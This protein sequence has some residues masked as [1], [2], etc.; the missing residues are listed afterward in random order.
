MDTV[1]AGIC[2][3]QELYFHTGTADSRGYAEGGESTAR[4]GV[5][6]REEAA[7]RCEVSF[8]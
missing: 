1:G 3:T 4:L 8:G 2:Y 5:G 7:E 6:Y